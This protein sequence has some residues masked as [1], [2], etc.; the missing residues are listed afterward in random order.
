MDDK[1][2]ARRVRDPMELSD[3]EVLAMFDQQDQGEF[4]VPEDMVPD[5]MVYEWK[6]QDVFG[7]DDVSHIAEMRRNGWANVPHERHPG[8]FGK[9]DETGPIY[10]KGCVLMELP[11]DQYALRQRYQH[12]RAKGQVRDM[13]AQLGRAPSGTGPRDVSPK[14]QPRVRRGYE[15]VP[16]E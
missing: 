4:Y 1:G 10:R 12:I 3:A 15:P 13:E 7:K 11:A 14:I 16:V 9:P 5:G 6:R 2:P 8:Y